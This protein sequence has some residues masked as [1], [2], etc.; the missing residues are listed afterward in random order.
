M[1][2]FR[3]FLYEKS[4]AFAVRISK[5]AHYLQKN[6][7]EYVLSD[8]IG[9]SGTSIGANLTEAQYGSSR[10]DF[11]AKCYIALREATET[12]YWLDVLVRAGFITEEQ[13]TSLY[14]DALELKKLLVSITNT[15]K[16]SMDK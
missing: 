3:Q 4:L 6:H 14:N 12:L 2:N 11:L 15:T 9:R 16:K 13:Y 7:K 5:L 1:D 8:Q 10:K